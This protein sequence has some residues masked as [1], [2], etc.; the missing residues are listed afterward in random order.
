M[1]DPTQTDQANGN[2]TAHYRTLDLPQAAFLIARGH[3]LA[4]I[5]PPESSSGGLSFAVFEVTDR[6]IPDILAFESNTT[7]AA[8]SYAK[9]MSELGK[10]LRRTAARRADR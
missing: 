1:R 6:L 5:D 7:I 2:T 3:R 8:H 10:E 4:R 9:A